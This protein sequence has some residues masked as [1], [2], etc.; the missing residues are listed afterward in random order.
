M[1]KKLNRLLILLIITIVQ[2]RILFI[3]KI[4]VQAQIQVFFSI[5]GN[6]MIQIPQFLKHLIKAMTPF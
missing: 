3:L 1:L 6:I 2:F 5:P 4:K